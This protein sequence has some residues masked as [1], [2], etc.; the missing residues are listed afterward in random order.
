M[1]RC[2]RLVADHFEREGFQVVC[3]PLPI[4]DNQLLAYDKGGKGL[5]SVNKARKEA[6]LYTLVDDKYNYKLADKS[7]TGLLNGTGCIFR[8]AHTLS[9]HSLEFVH[10]EELKH[11]AEVAN[12]NGCHIEALHNTNHTVIYLY[13]LSELPS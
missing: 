11:V 9:I 10:D 3:Y 4:D 1:A 7:W 2:L 8:V 12:A 6:D 13:E 5:P